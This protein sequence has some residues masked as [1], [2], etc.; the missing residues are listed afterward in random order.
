MVDKEEI[1]DKIEEAL[2]QI[3]AFARLIE[4]D[5]LGRDGA[6]DE[7]SNPM[8]S[9]AQVLSE[10]AAF[11]LESINKIRTSMKTEVTA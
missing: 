6:V 5:A 11:C 3:H 7:I 9:L 8:M 2:F 1:V 4:V 10:K